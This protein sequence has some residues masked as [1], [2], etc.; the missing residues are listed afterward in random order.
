[1]QPAM[2]LPPSA[3]LFLLLAC[4]L[5]ALDFKTFCFEGHFTN[6]FYLQGE[7]EVP[8][9]VNS[10]RISK[11]FNYQGASPLTFYVHSKNES[12]EPVRA[13]VAQLPYD[14]RSTTLLLLFAPVPTGGYQVYPIANDDATHPPGAY[15]VQNLTQ[16]RIALLVDKQTYQFTPQ[17]LQV[18]APP[19][20]RT[21][22]IKINPD[23]TTDDLNVENP[24]SVDIDTDNDKLVTV[25]VPS[26]IPVQMA[27]LQP[28]GQ[29]FPAY[30]R[31]WLYRADIRTYVFAH[32]KDNTV[33]L[34]Q[35]VEFLK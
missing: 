35:Y 14:P 17:Q 24:E 22:T 4:P 7:N 31:K 20:P 12:G 25:A 26:K 28:N 10:F 13:P 32:E 9:E 19:P 3:F 6:L 2:T 21:R 23:A 16:R 30:N 34:K 33:R 15:R 5:G 8:I 11:K 29:W 18:I 1:M 27:Y